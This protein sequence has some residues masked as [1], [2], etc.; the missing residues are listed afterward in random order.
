MSESKTDILIVGAGPAGLFLAAQLAKINAFHA[1]RT[2]PG[3]PA[4]RID[5]R[6]VDKAEHKVLVGHADGFQCRTVEV[7]QSLGIAHRVVHEGCEVAEVVFYNPDPEENGGKGGLK[8]TQRVVDTAPG[9]SF[10]RHYLLG[11]ARVEQ[12]LIDLVREED[13]VHVEQLT[14]PTSFDMAQDTSATEYPIT[15]TL[16]HITPKLTNGLEDPKSGLYRSNLFAPANEEPKTSMNGVDASE[17]TVR[18]RYMVGCDGARSWVRKQIGL[19]LKGDSANT[20]WGVVDA[21]PITDL[22]TIRLKNVI[23]SADSGSILTV[24]RERG[25]V[26]FYV[27]LGRLEPGQRV[28]RA[29]V[30]IEKIIEKAQKIVEPYKLECADVEWYTCYEIGQRLCDTFEK[31]ERVFIAGDAC[32][33]HSPKAGQGMNTSMMDT[34]NLGWKLAS[35]IHG[36]ANPSVLSTYNPERHAVANDLIEFDRKIAGLFSGK[37]ATREE[38]GVSLDEFHALWKKMGKWT[39]GT[40]IEYSDSSIVAKTKQQ[41]YGIRPELASGILIGS[42]FENHPAICCGTAQDIQL[43]HQLISDGRWRIILFPGDIRQSDVQERLQRLGDKLDQ[44]VRRYTPA[45]EDIDSV[46][47]VLSVFATP[48]LDVE[49]Q[50]LPSILK[51]QKS[52]YGVTAWDTVFADDKSHHTGDSNTYVGYGIDASADVGC[53]VLVRPDQY[54]AGVWADAD[55]ERFRDL[56]DHVLVKW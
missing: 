16:R 24:P 19:E 50:K 40:A 45:G 43:Q 10:F 11:Q 29:E 2:R 20:Y 51:P 52:P 37:P 22:P 15:V 12:F 46:I 55:I 47:Q 39:T 17:E 56:L 53:V 5:Y 25:Y 32:H 41:T 1:S 54:V 8:E 26:R 28:N 21:I 4:K 36:T 34:Y 27:Q 38:A 18:A 44:V 35:V 42:H 23:H 3:Q 6:I 48:R 30:T 31:Q 7:F 14:E 49:K 9:T 13:G 33:T